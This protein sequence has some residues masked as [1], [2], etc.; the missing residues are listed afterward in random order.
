MLSRVRQYLQY[1]RVF[2]SSQDVQKF[3]AV[4][5]HAERF[6]G[7]VSLLVRA[8]PHALAVRPH[9]VDA[10]TLWD[11]FALHYHLPMTDA[12]LRVIVDMGANAGYTAADLAVRY[13][14]ARVVAIELDAANVALCRAN[15]APLYD[16]VTV[17]HAGV[18]ETSGTIRYGGVKVDDYAI[19]RGAQTAPAIS[20]ADL[21]LEYQLGVVDYLKM[22]IEG[23]EAIVLPACLEAMMIRHLQLEVHPPATIDGCRMI[24]E[25][26]GFTVWPHPAH[27]RSL[28]A[29]H[30]TQKN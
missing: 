7:N 16:R 12:P 10:I 2:A 28:Y 5:D 4:R 19:G 13:P 27:Q 25:A 30:G 22:D 1:R 29:S 18:W 20:P 6:T 24:L 26:S 15:L 21:V 8:V 9:T 23:A 14:S 11:A 17:I 3:R